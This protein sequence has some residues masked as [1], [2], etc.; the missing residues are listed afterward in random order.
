MSLFI[1]QKKGLFSTFPKKKNAAYR[2]K[3]RHKNTV[4]YLNS[5]IISKLCDWLKGVYPEKQ[6]N[7]KKQ[8]ANK[9]KNTFFTFVK[10][11]NYLTYAH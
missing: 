2:S 9:N 3:K 11:S 10:K 6:P 8:F 5:L 1:L 7:N 4:F